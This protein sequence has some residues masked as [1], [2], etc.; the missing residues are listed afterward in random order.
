MSFQKP[1]I[2]HKAWEQHK[3]WE[4]RRQQDPASIN[5][6]IEPLLALT[7]Q[8]PSQP[9]PANPTRAKLVADDIPPPVIK[10]IVGSHRVN[11]T[12]GQCVF[13]LANMSDVLAPDA[14]PSAH[15]V[16]C[17]HRPF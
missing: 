17:Q 2:I 3:T 7:P 8:D 9:F 6:P 4:K 5:K 16:D 13:C 15:W 14:Q 1:S 12:R 11:K 10:Q